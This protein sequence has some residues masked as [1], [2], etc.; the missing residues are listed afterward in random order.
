MHRKGFTLIEMLIVV[1]VLVTLMSITFRLSSIGDESTRRVNTVTRMQRL[2]NCLSGYHAAFGSYPP[3]PLHASQDIF[4]EADEH[5]S[6]SET[7]DEA[8]LDGGD[9]T[10]AWRQVKAACLA[11]PVACR[12]P[13][14]EG[15]Q[16]LVTAVAE[17]I[18][19]R[20]EDGDEEYKDLPDETRAMLMAGFDDGVSGNKN[21]GDWGRYMEKS[22][23]WQDIKLFQFGLMSFLLP[24]YLF[25]MQSGVE[26][27][28]YRDCAQ[29]TGNNREPCDPFTGEER[30][31]DEWQ[32]YAMK[33]SKTAFE[34]A[35]FANIP[36]QAVC[37]RWMPNL[38]GI[39]DCSHAYNFFGISIRRGGSSGLTA[40]P[41][42]EIFSPWKD[43]RGRTDG[44]Y[45][46]DG[47]TVVDGW[48][49]QLY[50]YSP[51]PYQ[52]YTLWSAGENGKTFP[53]WISRTSLETDT[54]RKLV[55]KWTLDDIVHLSN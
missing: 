50:Y 30:D 40:S 34:L 3:V 5:F 28:F 39:C 13:F 46:L 22:A 25:M 15:Y 27:G 17:E 19:Q 1:V 35:R 2:E 11:Q 32:K 53:P 45:L 8:I 12:Y 44:Q 6:Q 16:D 23:N 42:I 54:A 21:R 20:I 14:P 26:Q 29:W 33:S 4:Y 55:A 38:E 9:E 7:R 47:I 49:R 31:W 41:S 24:R 43:S 37:A 10:K 52:T 51:A 18:K 36:S 48:Y